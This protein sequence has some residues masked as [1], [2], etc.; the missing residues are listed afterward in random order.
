MPDKRLGKGL[1]AL[2]TTHTQDGEYHLDGSIPM[3]KVKPNRNQPRKEF[4]SSEP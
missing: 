4:N 2:I 3:D 1:E